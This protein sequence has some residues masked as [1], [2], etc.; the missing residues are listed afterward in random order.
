M[1]NTF[2]D[3]LWQL[4]NSFKIFI[5]YKD[6]KMALSSEITCH[7]PKQLVLRHSGLGIVIAKKA[8]LGRHVTIYQGV[9]IGNK[10]GGYPTVEN[11]VT[12]FGNSYI[13]GNITIGH[14]SV[15][16]CKSV[17]LKDVPPY[18]IVAGNP[19]KVIGKVKK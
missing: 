10:G 3:I 13:I 7:I 17:V 19:A 16:G 11:D 6:I 15:I 5:K 12:I 1:A 2:K 4:R 9:C 8:K 18:T 14:H